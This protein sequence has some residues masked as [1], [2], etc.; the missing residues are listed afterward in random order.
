LWPISGNAPRGGLGLGLA[1]VRNAVAAHGGIVRAESDGPN[2]GNEFVIELP[3]IDGD[4]V[5]GRTAPY[6]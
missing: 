4:P 6:E 1:V 3:A 2:Q 5:D